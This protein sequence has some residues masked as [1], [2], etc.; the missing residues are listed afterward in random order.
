MLLKM[1]FVTFF[2]NC[3]ANAS[4]LIKVMFLQ[5]DLYSDLC[6]GFPHSSVTQVCIGLRFLASPIKSLWRLSFHH[7]FAGGWIVLLV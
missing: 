2:R 5:Y 3:E 1:I 7:S 6:S 4:E